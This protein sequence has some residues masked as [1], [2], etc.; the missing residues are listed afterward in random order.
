MA[1]ISYRLTVYPVNDPS[2]K[3]IDQKFESKSDA[4][5]YAEELKGENSTLDAL[6]F[7]AVSMRMDEWHNGDWCHVGT[8][9]LVIGRD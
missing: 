2:I 5:K 3:V 4:E 8:E 7:K 6:P 1:D 9:L